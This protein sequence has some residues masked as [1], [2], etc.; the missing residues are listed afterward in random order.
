MGTLIAGVN[1]VRVYV[2]SYHGNVP[3]PF[4]IILCDHNSDTFKI[5]LLRV[6][7]IMHRSHWTCKR[8]KNPSHVKL[9]RLHAYKY[10]LTI[11][12]SYILNQYVY[13]HNTLCH[14]LDWKRLQNWKFNN[15]LSKKTKRL[16]VFQ[17]GITTW[18]INEK[19]KALPI[20]PLW[21]KNEGRMKYRQQIYKDLNHSTNKTRKEEGEMK[22][23][24]KSLLERDDYNTRSKINSRWKWRREE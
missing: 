24:Y 11:Y 12:F 14:S 22:E 2:K 20:F 8:D 16:R 3:F 19:R 10:N 4:L 17:R 7:C 6:T 13:S 1:T 18:R 5:E 23:T 15:E 21:A 9:K